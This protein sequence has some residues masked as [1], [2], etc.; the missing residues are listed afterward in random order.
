[1]LKREE[2]IPPALGVMNNTSRTDLRRVVRTGLT[3]TADRIR[4]PLDRIWEGL[5]MTGTGTDS[6][7]YLT[8]HRRAAD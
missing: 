4:L 1:M 6:H 2:R 7:P 5:T 3:V 8:C